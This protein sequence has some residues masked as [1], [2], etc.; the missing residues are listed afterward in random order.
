MSAL[1]NI[2]LSAITSATLSNF[3][4]LLGP[5]DKRPSNP[6]IGDCYVD[7]V[8][9]TH[10]Y[11]G[12]SADGNAIEQVFSK[13]SLVPLNSY[14]DLDRRIDSYQNSSISSGITILHESLKLTKPVFSRD[15]SLLTLKYDTQES[16]EAFI[17]EVFQDNL[18]M[19]IVNNLNS[20]VFN[21]HLRPLEAAELLEFSALTQEKIYESLSRVLRSLT[22]TTTDWT[23]I[24]SVQNTSVNRFLSSGGEW[25]T[26]SAM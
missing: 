12:K 15:R 22:T 2:G 9:N 5:Q 4:G 13:R 11:V 25:Q 3:K 1:V 8:G 24:Y 19:N 7:S 14:V 16:L 17:Q 20:L 21:S 18:G 26:P 10:R 6:Q 23:T